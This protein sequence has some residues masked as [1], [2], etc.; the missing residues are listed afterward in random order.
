MAKCATMKHTTQQKNF[1]FRARTVIT[2]SKCKY[3]W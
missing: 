2:W 3:T 1:K